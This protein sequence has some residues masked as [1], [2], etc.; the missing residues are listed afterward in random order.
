MATNPTA[1]QYL[2]LSGGSLSGGLTDTSG[3]IVVNKPGTIQANAGGA[4]TTTMGANYNGTG[5]A[6]VSVPGNLQNNTGA[7]GV[8]V[9]EAGAAPKQGT[10]VLAA[11]T[12]TVSNTGITA[13]S[14]IMLTSQVDGGTPG[15]VRVSARVV[16]TSFTITSSSGTD[17]STIGFEIFERG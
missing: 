12:N 13:N 11:G 14:R 16:G 2:P 3:N 17:T 9:S 5:L 4:S 7:S 6:S 8:K 15:F 10:A 1:V